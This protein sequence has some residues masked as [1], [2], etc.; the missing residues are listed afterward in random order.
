MNK[1]F[2]E[3]EEVVAV[4]KETQPYDETAVPATDLVYNKTYTV[5][6]YWRFVDGHWWISVM[7]IADSVYTEDEFASLR[8]IKELKAELL[9]SV[10]SLKRHY[11]QV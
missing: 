11:E 9:E 5:E 1:L 7:E 8:S 10:L 4:K 2:Y 3:G 6:R